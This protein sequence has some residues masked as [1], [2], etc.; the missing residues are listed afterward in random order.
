[1][2]CESYPNWPTIEGS[3]LVGRYVGAVVVAFGLVGSADA[4]SG[5]RVAADADARVAGRRFHHDRVGAGP[6]AGAGHHRTPVARPAHRPSLVAKSC[7]Q[8]QQQQ[9][10]QLCV[11]LLFQLEPPTRASPIFNVVEGG[12]IQ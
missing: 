7:V 9:N 6:D 3:V 10:G 1:M 12:S 4:G 2:L 8:K 5:R 11:L